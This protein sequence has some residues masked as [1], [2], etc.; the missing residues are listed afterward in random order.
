MIFQN[1]QYVGETTN[2]VIQGRF[3]N[4]DVKRMMDKDNIKRDIA[5]VYYTQT[6]ENCIC[7]ITYIPR[8]WRYNERTTNDIFFKF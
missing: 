2:N 8:D 6:F 3:Y 1:V 4:I 5:F 7:A